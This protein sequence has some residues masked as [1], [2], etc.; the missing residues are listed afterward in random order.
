MFFGI[1]SEI[2]NI[3]S[4]FEFYEFFFLTLLEESWQTVQGKAIEIKPISLI[5]TTK[6][7][8]ITSVNTRDPKL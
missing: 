8:P 6:M 7:H 3:I 4:Y 5:I 2:K 1:M